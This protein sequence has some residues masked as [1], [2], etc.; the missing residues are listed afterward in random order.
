[1]GFRSVSMYDE[2]R[3]PLSVLAN[4]LGGGMSSRLFSEVREK[5][6]LA[7][8]V[9]AGHNT[10]TDVGYLGISAGVNNSKIE[11]AIKTILTEVKKIKDEGVT[12]LEL[13]RAI[14][15]T[16]GRTDLAM[17]SSN[18]LAQICAD[19]VLF[20]GKVLTPE[21]ELAKIKAVTREDIV[22]VAQEILREDRLN[23]ALVGPFKDIEP[24]K[25]LLT[26]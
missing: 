4:I 23:L 18:F 21:E 20:E 12:D 7:Y 25:Q 24:F 26:L 10:S 8:Y 1:M 2:R 17:E 15:Q 3:Y 5:R 22:N 11:E 6:G 14:D 13:H 16:V 19:S 9:S